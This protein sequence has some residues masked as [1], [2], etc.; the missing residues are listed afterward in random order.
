MNAIAVTKTN[1][2]IYLK[3]KEMKLYGILKMIYQIYLKYIQME[4]IAII[5]YLEIKLQCKN[6]NL[7]ILLKI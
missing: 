5:K 2:Y 4:I 3:V 7:P 1:K 6:Q